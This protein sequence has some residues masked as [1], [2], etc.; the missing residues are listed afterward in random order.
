MK[1]DLP[2]RIP[3]PIGMNRTECFI[4][5]EEAV[6]GFKWTGREQHKEIMMD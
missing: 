2:G 4:Q 3:L 6:I 1:P 5:W